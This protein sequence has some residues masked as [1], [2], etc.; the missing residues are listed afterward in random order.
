MSGLD[1]YPSLARET[2]ILYFMYSYIC[3]RQLDLE[4]GWLPYL[5]FLSKPTTNYGA[6]LIFFG[7]IIVEA[8]FREMIYTK[9]DHSGH[10][11]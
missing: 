7:L 9:A 3:W 2:L 4:N 1:Q 8:F 6:D 10:A 11:V 5:L